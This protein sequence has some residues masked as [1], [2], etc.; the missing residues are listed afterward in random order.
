MSEQVQENEIKAKAKA[1]PKLLV[2]MAQMEKKLLAHNEADQ[3]TILNFLQSRIK[4]PVS[5]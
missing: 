3:Q 5:H 1:E 2:T 4:S